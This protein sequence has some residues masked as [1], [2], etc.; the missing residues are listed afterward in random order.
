MYV[1]LDDPYLRAVTPEGTIKWA[2][3]LGAMG[4]FTLTVG[5]NDL[6]YAACDDGFIYVVDS[7]GE[8]RKE[9]HLGGW[10]SYPVIMP[11]TT[12]LVTDSQDY[13]ARYSELNS[14]IYAL[15]SLCVEEE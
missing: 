13:S 2:V 11:D 7:E 9:I 15:T 4:G 10:P 12:V 5:R 8:I 1:S 3:P 14:A 6:I